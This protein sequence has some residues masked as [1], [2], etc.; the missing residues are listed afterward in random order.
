MSKISEKAAGQVGEMKAFAVEKYGKDGLRAVHVPVPKVGPRDV[1]VRV[2]A[3]SINPLDLYIRNGDFKP[4]LKYKTP[5]VL[6]HDVAGVVTQVGSEV[7]EYR[8]GD[9]IYSRPRD[10]RIGTFAE[11]IAID[12]AD[13][14]LKP[15]SLTME[16]AAAVPLVALTAWQTLVEV[17]HVQ[18]GRRSSF[19]EVPADSARQSSSSPS[20]WAHTPLRLHAAVIG[21]RCEVSAPTK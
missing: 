1:L 7:S 19:T 16:K 14:A 6:G 17:A 4:L 3:A 18:P 11:Y 5:F 9:E 12:Q 2:S 8:V 10:L 15:S 13:I 20:T 21:R